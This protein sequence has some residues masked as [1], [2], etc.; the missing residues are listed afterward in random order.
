MMNLSPWLLNR[1]FD[2]PGT[3]KKFRNKNPKVIICVTDVPKARAR[4]DFHPG[5]KS[6][7]LFK[8][9]ILKSRRLGLPVSK[10]GN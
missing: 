6:L 8:I 9:F 2:T 3:D 5:L 10:S 1:L 4:G 7:R